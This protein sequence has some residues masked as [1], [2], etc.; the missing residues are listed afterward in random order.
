M[1]RRYLLQPRP[2]LYYQTDEVMGYSLD[3][4]LQS[5]SGIEALYQYI[6][7]PQR[8][9]GS[10]ATLQYNINSVYIAPGKLLLFPVPLKRH[11]SL[12]RNIVL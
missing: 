4:G 7:Q 2:V 9:R 5:C 6:D 10:L 3:Q 8:R 12:F 11:L 1:H